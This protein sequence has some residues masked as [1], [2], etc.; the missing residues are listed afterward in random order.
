LQP[1]EFTD[2][3]NND[4]NI[5]SETIEEETG[6]EQMSLSSDNAE[7]LHLIDSVAD[8][9]IDLGEDEAALDGW[10]LVDEMEVDY[11]MEE[12]LDKMI[13]LAS[14]GTARPNAKSEQDKYKEGVQFK[15]RY[16]YSP[17][18]V[19]NNSRE[20]C[21]KMVAAKKLYR[22]EDILAMDTKVVNAGWGPNGADTYSIWLYKGGGLCHHAWLRKT[23]KFQDLPKGGGDVKSPRA[24][25]TSKNEAGVKNPKEV[26]MKPKDMKNEGFLKPRN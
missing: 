3:T 1:L 26:A 17:Q 22:K 10:E 18:R 4:Q 23:Y 20:F 5:D 25:T 8:E 16:Q 12:K 9:L 2:L 14:T 7:A 11:D 6:V 19:S 24:K 15:V 21:K 13:G